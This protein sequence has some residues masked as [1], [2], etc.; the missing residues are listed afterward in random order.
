MEEFNS[1]IKNQERIL[2]DMVID[3]EKWEQIT[4]EQKMQMCEALAKNVNERAIS[5][6]DYILMFKFLMTKVQGGFKVGSR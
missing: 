4:D 6:E 5:K 1:D 2:S 3:V